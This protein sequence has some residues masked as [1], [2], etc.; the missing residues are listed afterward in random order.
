MK[1]VV[2]R[3]IN[4]IQP[5]DFNKPVY[6]AV[7]INIKK[8]EVNA[9]SDAS[10]PTSVNND[11]GIYNAVKI[12]ID[13]PRVNTEPKQIYDY[14]EADGI[15]TYDMIAFSPVEYS[16]EDD[17][18]KLPAE[19]ENAEAVEVP[20][21]N[22]TSVEAEKSE[23]AE[24]KTLNGL[25]RLSFRAS[26]SEVKRPEIIP[27]EPILPR[28]DISLV[29]ENLTSSNK[30]VQAQ[31][32]EE[33]V[34]LAVL[35]PENAKDYLVSDVFTALI[36]ITQ[37]DAT[38]LAPPSQQQIEIRQKLIAN[39][40]AVEKDRN[41]ANNLPYKLSD[42]EVAIATILS[43][44]ELTERNK[45]YAITALGTLAELFIEDF[46]SKEG[47]VVPITDAPGVSAIV[48]ALK[49][50]PD[51]GVKLAAIDALRHIQRSEYKEEL[52]ALFALAATDPNP[53]VSNAAHK[54]IEELS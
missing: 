6:S 22:Y 9:G 32:I 17:I 3:N 54:S 31:Q 45:E 48:E 24:K 7:N 34:R 20:S 47:R 2:E 14:P 13:N 15:V 30:D 41:A 42:D 11:R 23:M 16:A 19:T 29:T 37:E 39:I 35:E 46:Q 12:N 5:I 43:P 21:P 49:K 8:P 50:D 1:S 53:I 26:E 44:M 25:N 10:K 38:K 33:I 27:S 52:S 40:I 4:M 51:S 28:V 36:N 18:K